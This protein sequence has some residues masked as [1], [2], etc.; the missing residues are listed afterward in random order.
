MNATMRTARWLVLVLACGIAVAGRAAI[1]IKLGTIAPEG[2][3]WH[4]VLLETRNKWREITNGQVELRIYAN[5]V[6]GGEDEM[7][8]KM[9]RR[10]LD[11]LAISGAGLPL[12]DASVDCLNLPLFFDS[13]EDLDRVR[14]AIAPELEASFAKRGY[15]VLDWAEAGSV[16]F[17]AKSPVRTVDDLRRLRLWTATGNPENESVAKGLGFRV[18]PLPATD[19]LMGL[20]TGLVEAIDV[21]PLFALLDRSYQAAP[22]MTNLPFAPLNAATV[23]TRSAWERI[24]AEYREPLRAAARQA[25]VRLRDDVHRSEQEAITEMKARG[26]KVVELDAAT[27]ADWQ[28]TARAIYPEL[29]CRQNY[30]ELFEKVMRAHGLAP[31][32]GAPR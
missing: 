25:A 4:D 31:A 6:L 9:Q 21:P 20:E 30:P 1:V 8:R 10:S 12:I 22:Y 2:S 23:I 32:S 26:L 11:A 16:Y 18:V 7:I 28:R 17:F 3:I 13:Y 5:G 15:V 24:P 27:Q 19:M 14:N 29:G